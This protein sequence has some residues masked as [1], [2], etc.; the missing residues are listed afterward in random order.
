MQNGIAHFKPVYLVGEKQ[1]ES[2]I[3]SDSAILL[4]PNC[5]WHLGRKVELWVKHN[6]E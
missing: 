3:A 2:H 4:L 1:I 5:A 6:I